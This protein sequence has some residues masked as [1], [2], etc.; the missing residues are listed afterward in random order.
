MTLR[1]YSNVILRVII[2]IIIIII[3]I[4][5]NEINEIIKTVKYYPLLFFSVPS[6][7]RVF[8]SLALGGFT[9]SNCQPSGSGPALS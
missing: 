2:I 4:K 6:S 1:K 7:V 8:S 3:I 5:I 9:A